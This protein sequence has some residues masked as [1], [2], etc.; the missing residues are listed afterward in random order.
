VSRYFRGSLAA[1]ATK[2]LTQIDTHLLTG[3]IWNDVER[4]RFGQWLASF[5]LYLTA[6]MLLLVCCFL[7]VVNAR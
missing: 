6:E 7:Q 3:E 5:Y 1:S 4:T 2:S